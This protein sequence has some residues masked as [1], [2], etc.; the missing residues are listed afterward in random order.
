MVYKAFN[1]RQF[2]QTAAF[3]SAGLATSVVTS[4][5][6]LADELDY[7]AI[8]IGSGYGGAIASLRLGQAGVKTLIIER[9]RRW[10]IRNVQPGLNPQD[11]TF[12]NF[13][14][15]NP[16]RRSTWLNSTTVFGTPTQVY[17]GVF[18]TL[19]ETGITVVNGA[20]F[21]GGSLVNN[22]IA[23]QPK[24]EIFN[25]VFN[26]KLVDYDE[27]DS[28]YYPRV[29]Q[30]LQPSP[31]PRDVLKTKYYGKT[32]FFIENARRAGYNSFLLDL[33]VDWNK[34]RDE[35]KG[36][37]VASVIDGQNWWGVNSGAKNS[38][39]NNYLRQAEYTG[40]VDVLTLHIVTEIAEIPGEKRGYRITCNKI[41]EFGNVIGSPVTLTCRYLFMAAGSV[42]TS[43]LL[44][45]AKAKG[46]LPKLNQFV[47]QFWGTNGDNIT[48]RTELGTVT[49]NGGTAGAVI[50]QLNAPVPFVVESLELAI[51]PDGTQ[52]CL[53]LG[54]TPP[55]GR[56]EYNQATDSVN[57]IWDQSADEQII[58]S[59]ESLFQNLDQYA[60][61][62][63]NNFGRKPKHRG[64]RGMIPRQ[65]ISSPNY[66]TPSADSQN[67]DAA[68]TGHPLG[69]CVLGKAC[70]SYGRVL[71][72]KGLYVVDGAL[73]PGST[74]CTNP[75]L[76]ISAIAERC[77]DKIIKRDIFKS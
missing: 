28:V 65:H 41:D 40:N 17:T 4:R 23:Y 26:R 2:I 8:V 13:D 9:G 37:R 21:G 70:D 35:I 61:F 72:Y 44:V 5:K 27:L 76:T 43:K 57:L 69:G 33:A 50:E 18:E 7:Q 55:A 52:T 24:K 53:G 36:T 47:G 59:T 1:R 73:I 46:T 30:M 62:N 32:R 68:I 3:F 19:V 38:L 10:P 75:F 48:T 45:K 31:I 11:Y 77:M 12:A 51:S 56:F 54:L 22:A 42:G 29:K 58:S 15:V 64:H 20:G 67:N 16:D 39:D 14:L 71:G 66:P 6:T 34:V 25:R 63:G 60:N 49:G 74:A